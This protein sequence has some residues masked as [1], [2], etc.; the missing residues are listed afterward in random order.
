MKPDARKIPRSTIRTER[1]LL[2]PT[3]SGDAGRAFEIQSDWDVTRMLNTSFPPSRRE[4]EGW[5]SSHEGEWE[6]RTA[7]RFAI[8][9]HEQMVGIVDVDEILNGEGSL[10][11]WLE[12]SSW[13]KGLA[14]EAAQALI[15]FVFYEV[16]LSQL[17]SGHASD[18]PVS[19]LVLTKLGFTRVENKD[20]FLRSRSETVLKH[21]YA[22]LRG[23]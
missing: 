18:N 11:Y 6:A 22:L 12:R 23:G 17:T 10:G 9:H 21:C 1:L 13:G 20:V 4:I 15:R 7:Y 19:G 3:S 2:R 14:F 8:E 5:F 16:G